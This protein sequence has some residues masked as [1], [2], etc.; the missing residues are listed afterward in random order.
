MRLAIPRVWERQ[1]S[2]DWLLPQK[3]GPWRD[4]GNELNVEIIPKNNKY[5]IAYEVNV[6]VILQKNG[7]F[8][9]KN[10]NQHKSQI[11]KGV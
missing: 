7:F 8:S 10:L 11:L 3:Y 2:W 9:K 6:E 5:W 4:Q 1:D